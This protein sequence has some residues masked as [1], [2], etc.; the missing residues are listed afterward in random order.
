MKTVCKNNQCAGCMACVDICTKDAITIRDELSAYNAVINIEKCVDC[1]ACH[2]ICPQNQSAA[3]QK[4][5]AWYQGWSEEANIRS[6]GSSGG[7]AGAVAKAFI[8]DGGTVCSCTFSEGRFCFTFVDNVD[9][10]GKYAGSKYVKSDP[11]GIYRKISRRLKEGEK[12]LFIG[13]PCQVSALKRFVNGVLRERLYTVDLICHGTPSPKVLELFLQQYNRSLSEIQNIR[14]RVKDKFQIYEGNRG[15]I[16]TGVTDRYLIAFLNSLPYTENCYSCQYAKTERTSDLTLGDSWGSNLSADEKQRGV[17]LILAQTEKGKR[18]LEKAG[19]HLEDVDA[20]NAV[21]NNRQL[22]EP[23]HMPTG[24][25]NFF[26]GLK[27]GKKFNT[28]VFKEFPKV[29]VKQNIK[30]ILIRTGL[31]RSRVG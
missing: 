11:C 19:L 28:L 30:K 17:S 4:P 7:A 31:R 22:C 25:M 24:R 2:N 1:G 26:T 6:G 21:Q 8:K 9:E 20:E 15:V 12:I 29:C 10:L 18:L 3:A 5:I 16:T 13:L 14:F 27:K 23:S